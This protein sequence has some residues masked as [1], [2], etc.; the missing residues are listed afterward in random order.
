M[1]LVEEGFDVVSTDASDKMLKYALKERWNRR[2]ETAFDNWSEYTSA[3]TQSVLHY[4]DS[5]TVS[6]CCKSAIRQRSDPNHMLLEC[7][8]RRV[9]MMACI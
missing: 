9:G 1:L 3:L 2:K 8:T 5:L 6:V 4:C 7:L